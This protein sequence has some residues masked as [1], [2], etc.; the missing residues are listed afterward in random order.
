MASVEK[1]TNGVKKR[2][3]GGFGKILGF[4]SADSGSELIDDISPNRH[5][6]VYFPKQNIYRGSWPLGRFF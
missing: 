4:K 5:I 1:L 6:S 3:G 2:G